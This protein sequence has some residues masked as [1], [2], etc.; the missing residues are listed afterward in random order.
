MLRATGD[1]IHSQIQLAPAFLV[2]PEDADGFR[3]AQTGSATRSPP[4]FTV[5]DIS[6]LR[7]R[8]PP[9][10]IFAR[11]NEVHYKQLPICRLSRHPIQVHSCLQWLENSPLGLGYDRVRDLHYQLDDVLIKN[12]RIAFDAASRRHSSANFRLHST[13]A[14]TDAP[15]PGATF[16]PRSGWWSNLAS[17]RAFAYDRPSRGAPAVVPDDYILAARVMNG[18]G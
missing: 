6:E 13:P 1:V 7:D 8:I 10:A 9:G 4:H 3:P 2:S 15:P 17:R 18:A 14:W 11:V 16:L 5:R 12:E